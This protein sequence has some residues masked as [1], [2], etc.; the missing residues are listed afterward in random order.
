M[1]K[2][3]LCAMNG[4]VCI[5]V[6]KISK[7]KEFWTQK[8]IVD[9]IPW[10]VNIKKELIDGIP[11]LGA[12]LECEK[13]PK[14]L[15]WTQPV[16]FLIRLLSFRDDVVAYETDINPFIFSHINATFGA[17]FMK[18]DDLFDAKKGYVKDD[19]IKLQFH[20]EA[21]DRNQSTK[22]VLVLTSIPVKSQE[23]D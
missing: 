23:Q 2:S 10:K 21:A 1:T 4:S 9:E 20:V 14:L 12:Y 16:R 15:N 6:S 13:K 8:F 17:A 19:T 18:W 3:I 7:L 22:S 11:Y 5:Y